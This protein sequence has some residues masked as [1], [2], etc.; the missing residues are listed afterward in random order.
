MNFK[1]NLIRKSNTLLSFDKCYTNVCHARFVIRYE[2]ILKLNN[3][4]FNVQC[5]VHCNII[6]QFK[7]TKC[8]FSKL[9]F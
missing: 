4:K 8:T 7:P 3:K 9:I 1:L 6:M 2:I 5:T